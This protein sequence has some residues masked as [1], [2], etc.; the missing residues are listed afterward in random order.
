M[1]RIQILNIELETPRQLLQGNVWGL[2]CGLAR[3]DL[4]L[5]PVP[6]TIPLGA[7]ASPTPLLLR[8]F[9]GIIPKRPRRKTLRGVFGGQTDE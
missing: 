6:Q 9:S 1:K 2:F 4:S 3:L 5:K 8:R 7:I